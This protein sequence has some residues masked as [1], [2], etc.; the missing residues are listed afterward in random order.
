MGAYTDSKAEQEILARD[1][2]MK[3]APVVIIY[4]GAVMG[5]YDPHWGDGTSMV[6]QI[7]RRKV[8]PVLDSHIPIV[9]VRDIARIHSVVLESG[10]GPRRY[11]LG[12]T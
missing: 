8:I 11:M 1:F 10:K 2:Q 7:L 4:P 3:G 12:G 5:P 6:E 9:D